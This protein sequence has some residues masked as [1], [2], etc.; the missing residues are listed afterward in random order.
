MFVRLA[1]IGTVEIL[2][3]VLQGYSDY[4]ATANEKQQQQ[5]AHLCPVHQLTEHIVVTCRDGKPSSYLSLD[6]KK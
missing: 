5:H 3:R 1:L 4:L 2:A 6:E